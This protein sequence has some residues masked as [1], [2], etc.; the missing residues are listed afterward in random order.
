M[1][2]AVEMAYWVKAPAAKP[3]NLGLTPR[4][5]SV[6]GESSLPQAVIWHQA[7]EHRPHSQ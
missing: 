2:R 4:T 3:H 7:Q 5:C 6:E 1:L